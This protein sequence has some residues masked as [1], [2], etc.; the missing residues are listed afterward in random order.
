MKSLFVALAASTM[1]A[2]AAQAATTYS[3]RA[4]FEAVLGVK[5]TDTYEASQGYPGG[6]NVLTDAAMSAVLGETKYKTTGFANNNILFSAGG[7]QAYCAGCNGSFLLTFDATSFG[8]ANGVFGVGVDVLGNSAGLP[9][10]AWV[11]FGDDNVR[12]YELAA[13]PFGT[14]YF[15]GLTANER[16]KSIHFG[17]AEGMSTQGGSFAID[18]LTI[19]GAAVPEPAT[20]ALMIGGFSLAGASLRRKRVTVAFA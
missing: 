16:I 19:G 8:T 9:Y 14:P 4:A 11:T 10:S 2:G 12:N 6:F 3:D 20:W 1:L 18:N 5:L 17:L 15:F 7:N 13:T